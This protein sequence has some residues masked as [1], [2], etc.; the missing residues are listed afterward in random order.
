MLKKIAVFLIVTILVIAFAVPAFAEEDEVA[1]VKA[2]FDDV[3][4]ALDARDLAAL[5]AAAAVFEGHLDAYNEFGEEEFLEL[6][7][8]MGEAGA[9]E[10]FYKILGTW[11][12]A[13]VVMT[14][15]DHYNNYKNDANAGTAAAYVDYYNSLFDPEYYDE[16]LCALVKEFFAD[17][18]AVFEAAKAD[19]P[20]EA[21][22]AVYNAYQTLADARVSGSVDALRDAED[23]Y[24]LLTGELYEMSE[25]DLAEL[26]AL[27]GF[28]DS[29]DV[30]IAAG[31][32]TNYFE[33]VVAF[34]QLLDKFEEDPSAENALAVVEYYEWA[35]EEEDPDE[36]LQAALLNYFPDI[37]DIYAEAKALTPELDMQT[38]VDVFKELEAAVEQK[39]LDKILAAGE[40][41]EE[42]SDMTEMMT[43]DDYDKL[44]E[45]MGE[46][47]AEDAIA[48]YLD[49]NIKAG[50]VIAADGFIEKYADD[51]TEENAKALIEYYDVLFNDAESADE[52]L[53]AFVRE[54]LPEFEDAYEAAKKLESYER[55]DIAGGST[56]PNIPQTGDDSALPVMMMLAMICAA[57]AVV[58]AKKAFAGK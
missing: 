55:G 36:E 16:E 4:A 15:G 1:A 52:E 12:N 51:P 56:D 33:E 37:E 23:A 6:A 3:T 45:L 54:V 44:A 57:G 48:K 43:E 39:D 20:S 41:V 18:E 9:E 46:A 17:A 11:I 29:V 2:A 32:A 14:F 27:M 50:V 10:V 34:D 53:R 5:K 38:L 47:S 21:V 42:L 24:E 35:F 40:K 22:M 25:S 28:A 7:A 31:E 49:V 30:L 8:L 26:A 19:L 58:L 13:N